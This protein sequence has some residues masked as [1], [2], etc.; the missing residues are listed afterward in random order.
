MAIFLR[1]YVLRIFSVYT[2]RYKSYVD[3]F[4][5]VSHVGSR[6]MVLL[7]RTK[8]KGPTKVVGELLV[9]LAQLIFELPQI[10]PCNSRVLHL[11]THT[12]R[13]I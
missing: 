9:N 3:T 10:S 11:F 13:W 8:K 6:T 2:L 5:K 7:M 4:P 12:L 1:T